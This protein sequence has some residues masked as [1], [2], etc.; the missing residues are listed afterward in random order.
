MTWDEMDEMD[1]MDGKEFEEWFRSQDPEPLGVG[2]YRSF[3]AIEQWN[4]RFFSAKISFIASRRLLREKDW[5][6]WIDKRPRSPVWE[7]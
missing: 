2:S 4:M 5:K 3:N 1:E 7:E 6:E